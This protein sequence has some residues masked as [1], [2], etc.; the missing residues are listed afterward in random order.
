MKKLLI[1]L[2]AVVALVLLAAIIIPVIYKDDI[3][4]AVDKALAENL[5]AEVYYD[6]ST[7]D[8]SLLSNFPNVTVAMEDFGIANRAPFEG[9]TL[10]S[11]GTFELVVNLQSVLF[12]EQPR[13]SELKLDRANLFVYVKEDGSA[14]YD[15]AAATEEET[16]PADTAASDFSIGIDHWEI[17]NANIIYE[18]LT[19]PMLMVLEN[20][21]HTGSGDFTLD[22]FDMETLTDIERLT[23]NYDGVEY[24]TDKQVN[25]DVT[26][27]MDLADMKFTFKDNIVRV[28]DFGLGF[29]G[30]FAMPGE[31]MEMDIN[32]AARDNTFKSLFSLVPGAYQSDF[33][34]LK[35]EGTVD[36]SGY[37]R[38]TYN[39]TS[40]P[41]FKM[42]LATANSMF[43]YPDLPTAV[44]N[45][46][47]DLLVETGEDGKLDNTLVNLETFHAQMGNNPIEAS[48]LMRGLD[49]PYLEANAEV[50]LDLGQ[51]N[52]MFPMDSLSFK[53][54][55]DMNLTAQGTYDST[56]SQIPQLNLAM[57]MQ[58]GYVKSS[59]YPPLEN[60]NFASSVVNESGQLA[61]TVVRL[62]DF[63]MQLAGEPFSAKMVLTNL[64]D[65]TWDMN[66]NGALDLAQLTQIY[67]LEGMELAGVIRAE[68]ASQGKMSDVE[69]ENY[70]AL[71]TSGS[72]EVQNFRYTGEDF[73]QGFTIDN[74][75]GFFDPRSITLSNFDGA[76]GSTDLR[77]NGSIANYIGYL[78]GE[79]QVLRGEMTLKSGKMDL[80]EFMTE[81]NEPVEE[82]T[83]EAALEV[84]EI[85]RDI[86]FVFN[87]NIAEVLYDDLTLNNFK[88]TLVVR[89]GIVRM[90]QLDFNTLGGQFAMS[91]SYD[92]RDLQ[93]PAFD[94]NLDIAE[95][96]ISR[97]YANFNTVQALAPIAQNMDGTFS[98]TF[99][100]AGLL[101]PD[102]SPDMSTLDGRG[103]L[104]VDDAAVEDSRLVSAITTV[105]KLNNTNS[106][107][108]NDVTIRAEIK[109]GR[110]FVEPFD[111]NI[112]NFE[113]TL[114]GSNGIDGSIDYIAKMNIPAGA[115][116]SA[117]NNAIANL[118][119]AEGPVSSNI[120]LNLN[121]EGTYDDPKVSL[122][123]A[124]AGESTSQS[125]KAAVA[126]QVEKEKEE[127]QAE[128]EKQKEEAA[129]R[130]RAEAEKLKEEAEAKAKEEAEQAREEVKEEVKETQ[131]EI[132][133][134]AKKKLK[135]I[136]KPPY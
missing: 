103:I 124:E 121:I 50:K 60:I 58:N 76:A 97:A 114:A 136:F 63:G 65:Y 71:Q 131:E 80:N 123:G 107:T 106:I 28:N 74:A 12:E 59:D 78:F 84:V 19:L 3:Q 69:A 91:G 61:Q 8:L 82:D 48:F 67:P 110:V 135:K 37:I 64:E 105:S 54:N 35:A 117:V 29:D 108:L 41:A 23:V 115:V 17:T 46:D 27:L 118:T 85:P 128:L 33:D 88:G 132:K 90:D 13:L 104:D 4:A 32:Y 1:V 22:V 125:A 116:G 11:V 21:N 39:D 31:D 45:I 130:A 9:D 109:S 5:N 98:T 122:A 56:T 47:V 111:V 101:M 127:L 30:F 16:T 68:L 100:L 55:L 95:L 126:S 57:N 38:G 87:S 77:M 7:F 120:K 102:M 20:V 42:Q 36:F 99:R 129:A 15:I 51:L 113:T 96:A 89:D 14:N 72:M 92:P 83:A 6:I 70:Q 2:A 24:M 34:G 81:D 112:G 43:Q 93:K 53:G 133:E 44:S 66:V 26:M 52:R 119:G 18:D 40:L 75:Q 25:A 86:D 79:N 10:V 62:N 94:F 73:P 134:E 49:K